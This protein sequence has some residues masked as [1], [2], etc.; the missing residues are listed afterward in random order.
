MS[1]AAANASKF[2]EQVVSENLVFTLVDGDGYLVFPVGDTEV[3]PFWSSRSRLVAIQKDHPKF[4]KWKITEESLS[5]FMTNSLSLFEEQNIRVG[6]NWGGQRLTGFDLAV[7]DLRQNLQ[8]WID[9][10]NQGE[11][12][13][14]PN[15]P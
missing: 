12:A 11:Q 3:V 1:A 15:G 10:R 4:S 5:E 13:A 2:Y 14:V 6:V 7:S 9:R 8:Y